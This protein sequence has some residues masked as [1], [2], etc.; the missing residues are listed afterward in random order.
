MS[1]PTFA[2]GPPVPLLV[3]G[4]VDAAALQQLFTELATAAQFLGAKEKNGPTS[5]TGA[6]ELTLDMALARLLSGAARA[7]QIRY[8]FDGREWTDTIIAIPSGFRVVRC[9]HEI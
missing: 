8:R 3:E 2:D 1:E 9:R 5:L 6:D 4:A 7:I